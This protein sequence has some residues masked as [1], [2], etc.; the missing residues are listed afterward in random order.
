LAAIAIVLGA[1]L[2]L[3]SSRVAGRLAPEASPPPAA[4]MAA[5]AAAMAAAWLAAPSPAG[6]ALGL[7]LLILV[8]VDLAAMRLPDVV[9]LPSIAA[10]LAVAAWSLRGPSP[11]PMFS[12]D[13]L[14]SHAAGAAA[15]YVTLAALAWLYRR[16]RGR[17]GLGLGDAKLAALAGAW[18]GWRALPATVL[19]ACAAAFAWAALRALR[20]GRGALAQPLPFGPPLALGI[21]IAWIAP[22]L[23]EPAGGG[24]LSP[25]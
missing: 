22:Q 2:G 10:G 15:G 11:A 5:V 8:A 13:A 21:W 23:V 9:T 24:P 20:N 19:I 4:L 18:L 1:G 25:G 17:E 16:L 7:A 12:P 6:I 3:A 14:A